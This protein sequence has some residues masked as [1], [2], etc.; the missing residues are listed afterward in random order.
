MLEKVYLEQWVG[1]VRKDERYSAYSDILKTIESAKNAAEVI[2]EIKADEAS[3]YKG[4][5]NPKLYGAGYKKYILL[6]LE[7]NALEHDQIREI[8][9]KSIEHVLPQN[10]KEGS[11]WPN[12]HKQ[13]EI[14]QY[15]DSVG[16]S[17]LISKTKNSSASNKDFLEKKETYLK[18]R[19]SDYP[20]SIEVLGFDEWTRNVIDDRTL[21]AQKGFLQAL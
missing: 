14:E 16:N 6:R 4:V 17:V 11:D 21:S 9:A 1:G 2:S 8:E 15:V 10:P 5:S 20:R 7:L 19:V 12:N 3:I 18:E 13:S